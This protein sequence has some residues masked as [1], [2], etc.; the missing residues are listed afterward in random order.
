MSKPVKI[1]IE[2]DTE[3]PHCRIVLTR[4]TG[5]EVFSIA[6]LMLVDGIIGKKIFERLMEAIKESGEFSEMKGGEG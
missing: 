5:E 4:T 6:T 1:L 2:S 3:A